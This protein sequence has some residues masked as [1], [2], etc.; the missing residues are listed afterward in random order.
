[1]SCSGCRHPN[2]L[3]ASQKHLAQ[4]NGIHLHSLRS[5]QTLHSIKTGWYT[6]I[7][8]QVKIGGTKPALQEPFLPTPSCNQKFSWH[9]IYLGFIK[10]GTLGSESLKFKQEHFFID[11]VLVSG[12]SFLLH[13]GWLP[14][15]YY[16]PQKQQSSFFLR[17]PRT[18]SSVG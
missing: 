13:L 1:M 18:L 10:Q 9:G 5:H 17:A 15:L 4:A 7:V 6:S 8:L 16:R 2:G 14:L 12:S 3:P 11:E